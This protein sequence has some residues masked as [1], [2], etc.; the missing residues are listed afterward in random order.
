MRIKQICQIYR[1]IFGK[2]LHVT[3]Q[4][5]TKNDYTEEFGKMFLERWHGKEISLLHLQDTIL[6]TDRWEY[7]EDLS[8]R[9]TSVPVF[10]QE[11]GYFNNKI[12]LFADIEHKVHSY[13]INT[14]L[15]L[16]KFVPKDVENDYVMYIANLGRTV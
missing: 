3:L 1:L 9:M 7:G 15:K 6:D 4:L 11:T 5:N 10:N 8:I 13:S 2:N 12:V 16:S 14:L